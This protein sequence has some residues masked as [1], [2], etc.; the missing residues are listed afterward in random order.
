MF[1]SIETIFPHRFLFADRKWTN[2][3]FVNFIIALNIIWFMG[4]A[5]VL[6]K[7]KTS[8]EG[9]MGMGKKTICSRFCD[10]C[11]FISVFQYLANL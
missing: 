1:A 8:P 11:V 3:P 9:E 2:S 6:Q 5:D 4:H 10:V 7:S